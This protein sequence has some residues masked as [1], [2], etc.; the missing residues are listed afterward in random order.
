MELFVDPTA[1]T[2]FRNAQAFLIIYFT[3]IA[4]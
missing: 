3:S 2:E 1:E 4:R